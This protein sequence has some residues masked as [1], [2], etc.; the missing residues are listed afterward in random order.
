MLIY[1]YFNFLLEIFKLQDYNKISKYFS[2]D[3]TRIQISEKHVE[4]L[5]MKFFFKFSNDPNDLDDSNDL[6][7]PDY[8]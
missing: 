8:E 1:N 2:R 3:L 5:T 6:D 4:V 7:D